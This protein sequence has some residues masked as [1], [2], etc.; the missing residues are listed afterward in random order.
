MIK[1]SYLDLQGKGYL[2]ENFDRC[3][4]HQNYSII[5]FY[6]EDPKLLSFFILTLEIPKRFLKIPKRFFV[7]FSVFNLLL[8][9]IFSPR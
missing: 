9:S 4:V 6:L 3:L 2:R 5:I 1:T 7:D 8:L